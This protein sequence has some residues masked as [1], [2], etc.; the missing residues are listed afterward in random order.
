MRKILALVRLNLLHIRH[1]RGAIL[2]MTL[3]PIMLTTLLGVMFGSQAGP[4]RKVPVGFVD[5][6]RSAY[7]RQVETLLKREAG[8]EVRALSAAAAEQQV[9]DNELAAVVVVPAGFGA[10]LETTADAGGAGGSTG[11]GLGAAGDAAARRLELVKGTDP[12]RFIGV[13]EVARGIA[14]RL[15][16]DRAS[17]EVALKLLEDAREQALRAPLPTGR[18][19]G[20]TGAPPSAPAEPPTV[21][22]LMRTADAKWDPLPVSVKLTAVKA[23]SERGDSIIATGYSQYSLGM[24]IWFVLM[25]VLGNAESLLEERENGTLPRLLTTPT[26]RSQVLGG[27]VAGVFSVGIVQAAILIGFGAL[28][29]NVDWGAY[30]LAVA[31]LIGTFTLAATG[32]AI[33]VSATARTRSQAA[34]LA[35]TLAVALSMLGGCVWPIE[36]VPPFMKLIA[37]FTPTGWAMAGLTDV[38]VRNQGLASRD[39]AEHRAVGVLGGVLPRGAQ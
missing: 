25:L 13:Q 9:A 36:V 29:F 19:P 23:S 3:L 34:G 39:P 35:P 20:V 10:A 8:Y 5:N 18:P 32:L 15:S 27:K 28:A 26:P 1:D 16:V 21:S 31:L 7:S 22:A 24:T 11:A 6:D 38:V 14:T 12:V 17:A 30:P 37:L 4:E 33:L 2:S